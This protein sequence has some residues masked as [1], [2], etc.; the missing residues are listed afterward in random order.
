MVVVAS[1]M[2]SAMLEPGTTSASPGCSAFEDLQGGFVITGQG[3]AE[4]GVAGEDDQSHAIASA[5]VDQSA[6]FRFGGGEAADRFRPARHRRLRRPCS[7]RRRG[8]RRARSRRGPG[9]ARLR[10]T[11]GAR[12]RRRAGPGRG[13]GASERR[14]R[15]G[16]LR[17]PERRRRRDCNR[18]ARQSHHQPMAAAGISASSASIAGEPRAIRAASASRLSAERSPARPAVRRRA[19]T[20]ARVPAWRGKTSS[21]TRSRSSSEIDW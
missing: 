12:R 7:G 6:D 11:W 18:R 5:S 8:R 20:R 15:P 13:A 10:P 17:R 1:S 2:A 16:E 19:G 4:E 9:S 21:P 14:R 3:E